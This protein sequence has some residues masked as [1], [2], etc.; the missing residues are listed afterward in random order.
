MNALRIALCSLLA[1]IAT[2]PLMAQG[3]YTQ[4]DYPGARETFIY[5]I[6]NAG[7]IAGAYLESISNITAFS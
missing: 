1:L 2:V 5:G 7:D 6:N 4:I 3:T